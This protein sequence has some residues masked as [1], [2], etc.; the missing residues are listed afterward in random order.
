M[1][2]GLKSFLFLTIGFRGPS[3]ELLLAI[4]LPELLCM[5]D[6]SPHK[7]YGDCTLMIP[8]VRKM[9]QQ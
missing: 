9:M 2:R 8:V 6:Y 5:C 3:V 1:Y 7:T 4:K